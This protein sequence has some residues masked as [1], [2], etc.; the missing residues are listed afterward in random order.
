M[1]ISF[2]ANHGEI[3]GGEVMLLAMAT[4]ARELGHNVQIVAPSS[5]SSVLDAAISEQFRVI[6]IHGDGKLQYLR[7]LRAWAGSQ[8]RGLLWCNGLRPAAAT[9]SLKDR[10][11]HL[12][13]Q[14]AGRLKAVAWIA[15]RGAELV[16]VP[17]QLLKSQVGLGAHVME[18]WTQPVNI[19]R[20]SVIDRSEPVVIGYLGRLSPD[21]GV[22]VLAEAV[23]ELD[24][25]TPGGYRLLLA[26]EPRFVT[27]EDVCKVEGSLKE[28]S[29]ITT[30]AGWI[31]REEFFSTV[32]LAVF[33]SVWDEPF[34]LVVAEAMSAGCPFVITNAGALPSVA[35]PDFPWVA[36]PA[37]P[38]ALATTIEDALNGYI[39]SH[40]EESSR[41]WRDTY[42]PDAG[43][44]RLAAVLARLQEEHA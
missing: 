33:P 10:I 20:R 12:H 34:G 31:S 27:P 17:S 32:D 13:Q 11:V 4:A 40:L 19:P 44:E 36:P 35:G 23:K 30:R 8:P 39:P 15:T 9:A 22:D 5:P 21:K 14:P 38:S 28:V 16:L 41:R 6:G 42:S 3:G 25:R 37:D 18:N 2:A 43:R 1:K 26:G 29:A 24:Q 7:G